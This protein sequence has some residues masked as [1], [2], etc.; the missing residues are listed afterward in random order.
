[1]IE[2]LLPNEALQ[3]TAG[4]IVRAAVRCAAAARFYDMPLQQ[5]SGARPPARVV[6]IV[7]KPSGGRPKRK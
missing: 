5:N 6:R 1:M 3:L 7:T 2:K 4:I